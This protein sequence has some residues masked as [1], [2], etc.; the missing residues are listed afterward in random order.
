MQ[1]FGIVKEA[2]KK[3]YNL[4]YILSYANKLETAQNVKVEINRRDFGAQYDVAALEQLP[5]HTILNGLGELLDDKQK[6]WVKA[7]LKADTIFLLRLQL[8]Q[9]TSK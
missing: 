9:A 6:H 4:I 5:N 2:R 7:H 1:H 3:R 8:E